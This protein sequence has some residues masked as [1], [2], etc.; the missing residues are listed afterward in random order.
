MGHFLGPSVLWCRGA[1][2]VGWVVFCCVGI[3]APVSS[4]GAEGTDL[5][6]EELSSRKRCHFPAARGTSCEQASDSLRKVTCLV[7]EV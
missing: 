5:L 7:L 6:W 3:L 1:P 2:P 4:G